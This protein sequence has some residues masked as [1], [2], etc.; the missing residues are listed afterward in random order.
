MEN[1]NWTGKK[2]KSR[3][4]MNLKKKNLHSWIPLEPNIRKL[5]DMP[6]SK[7]SRSA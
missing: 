1:I 3:G 7:T 6:L 5:M 4:T 2:Y